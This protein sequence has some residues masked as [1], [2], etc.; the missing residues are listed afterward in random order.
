MGVNPPDCVEACRA[1]ATSALAL[2]V[3]ALSSLVWEVLHLLL[4]GLVRTFLLEGECRDVAGGV[5]PDSGTGVL[6][7]AKEKREL[8]VQLVGV[9]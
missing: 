1:A 6:F 4:L 8:L 9:L 2:T 3:A 5:R 7:S